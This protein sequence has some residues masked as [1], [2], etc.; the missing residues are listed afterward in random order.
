MEIYPR[1]ALRQGTIDAYVRELRD[2]PPDTLAGALTNLYRTSEFFPTVAEI[3]R[4]AA[5]MTLRLPTED[6]A[7]SQVEN[8]I[9]FAKTNA[10]DHPA[11]PVVAPVHGD[12]KRALDHVGGYHAFRSASEP[13]II[14]G[15]FLRL[16]REI[17][18]QRIRQAQVEDFPPE[19]AAIGA[20]A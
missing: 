16:Y 15:Q 17:R 3:R 8:R 14:R 18:E 2:L 10:D 20:A 1:Q 7:L 9:R 5:E 6:E 13:Q 12:V 4:V 19:R 11:L